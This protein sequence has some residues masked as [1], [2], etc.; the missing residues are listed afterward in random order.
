MHLTVSDLLRSR[1]EPARAEERD[2][3]RKHQEA[4]ECESIA[5]R[6]A[7]DLLAAVQVLLHG[8]IGT[9]PDP[10]LFLA[11]EQ[12]RRHGQGV[13]DEAL[14]LDDFARELNPQ[15]C[16][17]WLSPRRW[18]PVR[19]RRSRLRHREE[20]QEAPKADDSRSG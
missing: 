15:C 2:H 1:Y 11:Q 5:V 16:W 13:A 17:R 4:L 9:L 10:D 12:G 6:H 3:Q 18:L 14:S 8:T 19:G 20:S 7:S